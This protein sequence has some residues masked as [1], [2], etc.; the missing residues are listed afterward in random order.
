MSPFRK[1]DQCIP[2]RCEHGQYVAI[3]VGVSTLST[4][5]LLEK[6]YWAPHILTWYQSPHSAPLAQHIPVYTHRATGSDGEYKENSNGIQISS[7]ASESMFNISHRVFCTNLSMMIM[8]A[9]LCTQDWVRKSIKSI[10]DGMDDI[11][12]DDDVA[13]DIFVETSKTDSC[14]NSTPKVPAPAIGIRLGYQ[15][16]WQHSESATGPYI[17][18]NFGQ[19]VQDPHFVGF[20]HSRRSSYDWS[21]LL[22]WS[23][24]DT[25]VCVVCFE[26]QVEDRGGKSVDGNRTRAFLLYTKNYQLDLTQ[27]PPTPIITTFRHH[28]LPLPLVGDAPYC[29]R[30]PPPPPPHNQPP[31]PTEVA[32]IITTL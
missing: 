3:Y 9:L 2:H 7:V 28:H 10:I 30:L 31:P 32:T 8:E 29:Y 20:P 4:S 25:M 12:N 11:L 13:L 1:L 5:A 14:I 17:F 18:R 27:K 21:T 16:P 23:Q 22:T 24:V 15:Y 19:F 26:K 6:L